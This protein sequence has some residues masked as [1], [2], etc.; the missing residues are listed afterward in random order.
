MS[1]S[2]NKNIKIRNGTND[3]L[4]DSDVTVTYGDDL[5]ITINRTIADG[6]PVPTSTH[7]LSLTSRTLTSVVSTGEAASVFT[8]VAIG[9]LAAA[10]IAGIAYL[11]V[12]RKDDKDKK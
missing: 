9:L 5:P 1:F 12:R 7:T 10:A 8:F 3:L 2:T 4:N 6:T 11:I